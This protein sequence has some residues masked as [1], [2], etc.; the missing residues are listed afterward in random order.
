[1]IYYIHHR[2]KDALHYVHFDVSSDH[3]SDGM[4]YCTHHRNTGAPYNAEAAVHLDD[5]V[6]ENEKPSE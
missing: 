4:I 2:H 6:K 1:M 5:S 3:P